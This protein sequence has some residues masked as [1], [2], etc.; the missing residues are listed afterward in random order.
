MTS[1]VP[2]FKIRTQDGLSG[3]PRRSENRLNQGVLLCRAPS[4]EPRD[5]KKEKTSPA[6]WIVVACAVIVTGLQVKRAFF[7]GQTEDGGSGQQPAVLVSNWPEL[8]STGHRMGPPHSKVTIVEFADFECPV[9]RMFTLG[10]LRAVRARYPSDVTV[11]FRHWPLKYHRFA[12]PAAR[13]A[14]CAA[15]QGRFE[16]FHDELYAEQDSLGLKPWARY[17]ADAGVPDSAVFERCVA[18]SGEVASIDAD[19]AVAS[20]LGAR[21]TPAIIING[22]LLPGAPDSTKLFGIV[23]SILDGR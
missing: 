16:P 5:P 15:D 22:L 4:P 3:A 19:S 7:P 23:D 8:E 20:R 2:R 6:V 14:E 18:K 10:A 17:A 11:L 21:G 1:I 12:Y 13:A 9:C